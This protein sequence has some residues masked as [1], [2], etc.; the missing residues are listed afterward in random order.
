[1]AT[2]LTLDE[3]DKPSKNKGENVLQATP[4]HFL[5]ENAPRKTV[6]ASPNARKPKRLPVV[7]T[8]DEVKAVLSNLTGD[9]GLMASL[10]DGAGLRLMEC[11]QLRIQDLD[12]SRN[13]IRVRGGK[14]AKSAVDDLSRSEDGV[15]CRD[16][17]AQRWYEE[18]I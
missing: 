13:E 5:R 10:M 17:A 4:P 3:A 11:L 16:D 14:G 18:T 9:K 12:F 6:S 8:R 7:M 2:W 1:M 15:L